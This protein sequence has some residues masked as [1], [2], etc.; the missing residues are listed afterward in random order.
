MKYKSAKGFSGWGQLGILFLFVGAGF[1]ITG[2]I[3]LV[4]GLSIIDPNIPLAQK[5]EAMMKALFKPENSNWL[6]ISQISGT[7]FLMFLP[8]LIYSLICNGKNKLWLGFS[9]Y[10]NVWQVVLGFFIIYCANIIA[11][12]AADLSKQIIAHF[13][14]FNKWAQGL[15]DLYNEE[16]MAMANLKT[17]GSLVVA[18]IVIA[19]FPALFEEMFFRGAMQNLFIRWW[20]KPMLGI[21]VTALIFSFIH[22]S[23]YLF[24]SRAILGFALGLMYYQSKNLWVNIIAHFLNNGFIVV[25]LFIISRSNEKPDVSKMD[26][27]FPLWAELVSILVFYALFLLFKKLSASNKAKI[28]MDEQKLWI[29]S[30]PEYNLADNY[31]L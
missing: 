7:L 25:Q 6:Q 21:I 16:V 15:E 2:I 5:G 19:F 14:H 27:Q 22:G 20:K 8:A 4:I 31:P 24:L 1:V 13:P 26:Q 18:L 9:R 30:T 17:W 11:N 10:I 29:Q 12:P 28:E 3:Q 23:A